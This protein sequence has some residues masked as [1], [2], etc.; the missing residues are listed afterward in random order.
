M[1]GLV[2]SGLFV[3]SN[4]FDVRVDA[5]GSFTLPGAFTNGTVYDLQVEVQPSSPLQT[6]RVTNGQGTVANANVTDLAVVC[7]PPAPPPTSAM[8]V[9]PVKFFRMLDSSSTT[10]ENAS[11]VKCSSFS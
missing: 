2:G 1:T 9:L 5:S 3:R 8:R 7:D 11:G 4:G 10:P 6:C